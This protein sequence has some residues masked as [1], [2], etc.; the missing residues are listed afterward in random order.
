MNDWWT[1]GLSSKQERC[2]K[3]KGGQSLEPSSF[4][5]CQLWLCEYSVATMVQK[6][7]RGCDLLMCPQNVR[8]CV[9]TETHEELQANCF[10][11]KSLLNDTATRE[12]AGLKGAPEQW[13]NI[14]HHAPFVAFARELNFGLLVSTGCCGGCFADVYME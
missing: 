3:K 9:G 4:Q 7:E 14:P 1:L 6:G 2:L 5:C 12:R 13:I 8:N 10:M 11:R